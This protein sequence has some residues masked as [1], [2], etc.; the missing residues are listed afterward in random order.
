MAYA[1]PK[2]PRPAGQL[3]AYR[4]NPPSGQ[5]VL[6]ILGAVVFLLAALLLTASFL[7]RGAA[8]PST[9]LAVEE[10][11]VTAPPN[12]VPGISSAVA[13]PV[14]QVPSTRAQQGGGTRA[15]AAPPPELTSPGWLQNFRP[16]HLW[17]SAGPTFSIPGN[18][19][20]VGPGSW[21][22]GTASNSRRA[23][24]GLIQLIWALPA[25]RPSSGTWASPRVS[26]D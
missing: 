20:M 25:R 21:T 8:A 24:A 12:T 6:S 17:S 1:G 16:T 7:S 4:R 22:L 10:R 2:V 11:N 14:S 26:E 9:G 5:I 19:R 3:A 23:Q 15:F 18:P 13:G